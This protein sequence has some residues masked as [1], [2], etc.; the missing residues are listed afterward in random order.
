M[1]GFKQKHGANIPEYYL[2]SQS[3][4]EA[5]E[6]KVNEG[7]L[8]S[9]TLA[10]V[11]SVEEEEAQE[12]TKPEQ[13]KQLHLT[14]DANLTVQTRRGYLSSMPATIEDLRRKYCFMT[15]MRQL[16]KMRQP[17]RPMYA[18]LDEIEGS[19]EMVGPDWNHC[20]QY[21]FQLR[22]EA[23]RLIRDQGVSIQQA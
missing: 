10:Q 7:R 12:R 11:V 16:A 13:P 17:S 15:H 5:F 22:K 6:E 21:E 23:L 14:L 19:G 3:Y 4:F 18:D 1:K 20:L 2:P 9:E 8:R